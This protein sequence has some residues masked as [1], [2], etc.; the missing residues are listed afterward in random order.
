MEEYQV[1]FYYQKSD[2]KEPERVC[3]FRCKAFSEM[4]RALHFCKKYKVDFWVRDDD[5]KIINKAVVQDI[6]CCGALIDNFNIS[7]G[8][9]DCIQI[10]EVY[11]K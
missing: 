6:N 7:F 8:S 10:I 3:S 2:N 5:E 11:L 1:V 9:D 4:I